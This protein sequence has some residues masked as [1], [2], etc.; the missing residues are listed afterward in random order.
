MSITE[1]KALRYLKRDGKRL[2]RI[3][4]RKRNPVALTLTYQH[5]TSNNIFFYSL[6]TASLARNK[7]SLVAADFFSHVRDF[8][9]QNTTT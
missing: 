7:V 6:G 1:P 4:K 9:C 3:L 5:S 2:K 8:Q